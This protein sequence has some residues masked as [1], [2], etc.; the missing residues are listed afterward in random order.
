MDLARTEIQTTPGIINRAHRTICSTERFALARHRVN[1][2]YQCADPRAPV[3]AVHVRKLNGISQ[4]SL[5]ATEDGT[6]YVVKCREFVGLFGLVSEV[7]GSELMAR[8]GLPVPQ[9]E[10]I[11]LT[12]K[13]IRQSPKLWYRSR[14]D[15]K[16]IR[17]E[18]GMAFGTRLTVS[19]K[20]N[21]TYDLVP[22]SWVERIVNRDDF[23]GALLFDLWANNCDR[24][25]CVYLTDDH[26]KTLH[27]IFIDNDHLFGGYFANEKTCPRRAMAPTPEIYRGRWNEES[28]SHWRR[29]IDEIDETFIDQV[30]GKIPVEWLS[31]SALEFV[32]AQLSA[33][34]RT[35][36]FL[37][38]E[39]EEVIANG[40]FPAEEVGHRVEHAPCG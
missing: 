11:L 15:S 20:I 32:T 35:L 1:E 40:R 6:L 28:V 36:E 30:L 37:I 4:P 16:G 12:E 17:P 2:I 5:V 18:D 27:A 8:M 26:A 38:D 24:R 34:R 9:W 10:T 13:F 33:R 25:Q 39:V 23:V 21:P 22:S 31:H 29:K 3:A 7:F 14:P 19:P